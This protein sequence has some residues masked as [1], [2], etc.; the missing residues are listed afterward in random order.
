MNKMWNSNYYIVLFTHNNKDNNHNYML[1]VPL[2]IDKFN[3][4]NF[5]KKREEIT[6]EVWNEVKRKG[7]A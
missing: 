5:Y 1:V 4:K 7:I 2:G 6:K 3:E